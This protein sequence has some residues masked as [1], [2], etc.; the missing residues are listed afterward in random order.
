M[1]GTLDADGR[2]KF[3]M[4]FRG[5]LEKEFPEAIATLYQLPE[6]V[7][8]PAKPY[9]FMMPKDGLVFDYRFI[10]EVCQIFYTPG[11][12]LRFF[13]FFNFTE[14][15]IIFIIFQIYSIF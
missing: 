15:F 14:F 10:R 1:G 8:P 12:V 13:I 3:N 11:K 4:L 9:I 7:A 6:P 2:K 5:L